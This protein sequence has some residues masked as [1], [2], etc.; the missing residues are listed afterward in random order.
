MFI[1]VADADYNSDDG[2]SGGPVITNSYNSFDYSIYDFE[3]M[4]VGFHLGGN[5]STGY[6]VF[7]SAYYTVGNFGCQYGGQD[8]W[9]NSELCDESAGYGPYETRSW[10]YR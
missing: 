4:L 9:L 1:C 8:N 2:D 5:S 10:E 6:A 7:S 3:V